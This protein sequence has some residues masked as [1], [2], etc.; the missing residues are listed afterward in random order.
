[1]SS[2]AL[3]VLGGGDSATTFNGAEDTVNL[4]TADSEVWSQSGNRFTDTTSGAVI[5]A[6][7]VNVAVDGVVVAT[8]D[9]DG[10]IVS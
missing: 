2:G 4:T 6:T 9:Q 10:N 8:F 1:M 3:D 5:D 7:N